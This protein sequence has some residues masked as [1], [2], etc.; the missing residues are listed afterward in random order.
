MQTRGEYIWIAE[1]DDYAREDFLERSVS[2]LSANQNL[3]FVY[4]NSKIID[5]NK[6]SEYL[7]SDLRKTMHENK[8]SDDYQNH[9]LDVISQFLYLNNTVNNVSGVLFRKSKYIEAGHADHTMKYCGDWFLY[10][11]L[12]LISDIAYI[13]EP[14][15][16]IRFHSKSTSN[17]YFKTGIY[18]REVLRIYGFIISKVILTPSKKFGMAKILLGILH[19]RLK[20]FYFTTILL[21][22]SLA[23]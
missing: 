11:R 7:V 23:L 6:N 4:S 15:N 12:L 9:G 2:V 1:S 14:L 20:Y 17:Y 21:S 8:W 3:G 5:E 16:T 18:F 10:L 22:N 13:S 19:Q